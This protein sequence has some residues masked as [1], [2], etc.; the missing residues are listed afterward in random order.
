MRHARLPF[1][2]PAGA[3]AYAADSNGPNHAIVEMLN[4][5]E[6]CHFCPLK[7]ISYCLPDMQEE[8]DK[9]NQNPYKI[10]AF[11]SAIK[12]LKQVDHP[13]RSI[14][15]ARSVRIQLLHHCRQLT[16]CGC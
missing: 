16:N 7:L 1:L 12:V 5:S 6:G 2:T 13:L 11:K 8:E 4:R 14:E 15:E 3:R 9:E 10:R